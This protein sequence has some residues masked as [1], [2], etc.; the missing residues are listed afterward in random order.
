[1]ERIGTVSI[2]TSRTRVAPNG[3]VTFRPQ[4]ASGSNVA[5]LFRIDPEAPDW[6]ATGDPSGVVVWTMKEVGPQVVTFR[7]SNAVNSEEESVTV[8][9]IRAP[10]IQERV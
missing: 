8:E 3:E 5:W 4:V 10:E 7:A 2:S 6:T 9:V 1:M